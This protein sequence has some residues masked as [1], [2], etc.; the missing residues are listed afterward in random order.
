MTQ[1]IFA[2]QR[3]QNAVILARKKRV[4]ERGIVAI[5]NRDGCPARSGRAEATHAERGIGRISIMA[6]GD[7][8]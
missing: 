2:F 3:L 8:A 6:E 4:E 7:V 5:E 1:V